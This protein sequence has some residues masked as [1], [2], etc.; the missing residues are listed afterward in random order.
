MSTWRWGFDLP[1]VLLQ[2]SQ[3]LPSEEGHALL[4]PTHPSAKRSTGAPHLSKLPQD[5]TVWRG[6]GLIELVPQSSQEEH[7]CS[8]APQL[9]GPI[10]EEQEHMLT[11][12]S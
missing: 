12:S 2:I 9:S 6:E 4:C 1:T 10:V 3:I 7:T 8:G 5:P 11:Q